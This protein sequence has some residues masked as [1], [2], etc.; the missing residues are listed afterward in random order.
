MLLNGRNLIE[1][2]LC[3]LFFLFIFSRQ[4]DFTSFK[5]LID[6]D[7]RSISWTKMTKD[8]NEQQPQKYVNDLFVVFANMKS[9]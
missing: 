3:A 8:S 1:A 4:N 6:V 7:V 5:V 9:N 2:Q